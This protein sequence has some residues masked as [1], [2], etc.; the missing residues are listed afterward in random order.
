LDCGG[1]P[2][3]FFRRERDFSPLFKVAKCGLDSGTHP[4][5]NCDPFTEPPTPGF[6]IAIGD[7]KMTGCLSS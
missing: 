4:V 1:P 6:D 2:P 5:T 3:L 7:I